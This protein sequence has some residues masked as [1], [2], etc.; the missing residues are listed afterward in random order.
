MS[1]R[2]LT[3]TMVLTREQDG[4]YSVSVPALEGCHTQ[5]DDL[6]EALWMAQDA[7]PGYL[8][9]LVEDGDPIPPDADTVALDL[10]EAKEALVY[11]LTVQEAV[12]VP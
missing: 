11:K 9:V 4:G 6:P 12:P 10:G 2:E 3:Y 7:I 1:K 5:G 8:S